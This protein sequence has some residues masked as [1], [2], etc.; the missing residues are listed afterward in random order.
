MSCTNK[1]GSRTSC[2][3]AAELAQLLAVVQQCQ[4]PSAA[5][6]Q[7]QARPVSTVQHQV[8]AAASTALTP[9]LARSTAAA[10]TTLSTSGRPWALQGTAAHHCS[11]P[12]LLLVTDCCCRLQCSRVHC[13]VQA[14]GVWQGSLRPT[15]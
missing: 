3:H 7:P 8:P 11:R 5:V 1:P 14:L 12:L 13:Q 2:T 9:S 10:L 15:S 4:L 6:L